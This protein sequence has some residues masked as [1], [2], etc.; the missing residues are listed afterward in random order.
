MSD[1]S[2]KTLESMSQATW[3]NR[4][5]QTKFNKYL[6]GDILEV[7]CGIG[8][9]STYL[10]K[11][12]NLV[13][14]DVNE[15]HIKEARKKIKESGEIGFGDIEKGKYFFKARIFNTIVCMNVLE[16]IK[17]DSKAL[18]N[19]NSILAKDG[20]LI[21]LVPAHEFLF[22]SIDESIGHYRRY[23][24]NKLEQLLKENGFEIYK[25][26]SLNLIGSL[27]WFIAGKLLGEKNISENKIKMF[28]FISPA[29]LFLESIF[30][31]PFGTSI[32]VIARKV[33][34]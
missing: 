1:Q 28:N 7:G 23:E 6:S 32:L 5:T 20:Y 2:S 14:I 18:S 3:Y 27:G 22:N 13:G 31:P 16:H 34:K 33:E 17:N 15:D 24:K 12:G 10:A 25:I 26:R 29:F 11:H 4:W 9:F 19:I 30:E 21:L 8:N